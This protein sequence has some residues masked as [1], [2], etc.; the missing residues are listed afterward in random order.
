MRWWYALVLALL[1][2]RVR[3][4][5]ACDYCPPRCSWLGSSYSKPSTGPERKAMHKLMNDQRRYNK[6]D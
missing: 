6:D 5:V 2:K 4:L 1:E 3:F